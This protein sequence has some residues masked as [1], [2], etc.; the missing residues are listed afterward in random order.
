MIGISG[1]AR[2]GKDTLAENLSIIIKDDWGIDVKIFS[3]ANEIKRQ[4]DDFLK[5]N[6]K[7]SAFTENTK[8][9]KIIRDLLVGHGESTKL[10]H[11]K[12]V[13]A[14]FVL[15]EIKKHKNIFPII[16]D[17]R[18]D[19][20]TKFLQK[21]KAKVVHIAKE[22]NKPPNDIEAKNDPL[23]Q[24]IADLNHVWPKYKPNNMNE[25]MRHAEILWQMLKENEEWKKIYI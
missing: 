10:L 24:K 16:S 1:L 12:D 19:F 23:V 14:K 6:Y 25:C 21:N 13:W 2:S 11:G 8:E 5:A 22:G 9:K 15:K 3:F 20:E 17:V 18:F 7:I 4:T